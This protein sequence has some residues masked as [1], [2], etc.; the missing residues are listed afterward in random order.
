MSLFNF[1]RKQKVYPEMEQTLSEQSSNESIVDKK[2]DSTIM[3]KYG[4]DMP[5]DIIYS[6][7][8]TDYEE[9]GFEDALTNPDVSYKEM[10]MSMIK[11]KLEVKFR[12]VKLKY[13]NELRLVDFHINSRKEAGLIEI[14]KQLEAKKEVLLQHM[15]ELQQME[16]DFENKALYM[17]GMLVSYEK[18]FNKGLAAISLQQ[19]NLSLSEN[20]EEYV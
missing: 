1:L 9:K 18:G 17:I 8:K 7:L 13:Q 11:S 10:N 2:N 15:D 3:I 16:N 20:K 4:T 19:M 5:I 12:Q 6:F 14:V